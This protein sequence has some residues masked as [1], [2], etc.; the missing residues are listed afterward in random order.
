MLDRRKAQRRER[1]T[2]L[3]EAEYLIYGEKNKT[4]RHPNENFKNI[5]NL[6]NSYFIAINQRNAISHNT[7]D[8]QE[9]DV[10]AM[11]VLMK[12]ARIATNI[13]HLESW[14]DVAG[15]AGCAERIIKNK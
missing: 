6:W 2:I 15:Y 10:A 8:I 5:K 3:Q 12:I 14:V 9:I 1:S 13:N 4:Y 11:M 7:T